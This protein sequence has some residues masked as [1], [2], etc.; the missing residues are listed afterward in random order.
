M[1]SDLE[2]A[3]SVVGAGLNSLITIAYATGG[4]VG[5][6]MILMGLAIKEKEDA[7]RRKS[8]YEDRMLE[9]DMG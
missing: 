6:G 9:E 4:A 1:Q 3:H 2:R 5:M 7:K 8:D